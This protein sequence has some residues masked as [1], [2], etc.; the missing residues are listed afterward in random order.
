AE[1]I[2]GGYTAA[3]AER[4]RRTKSALRTQS[5]ARREVRRL[6]AERTMRAGDAARADRRNSKRAISSR[7]HDAKARIDAARVSG[8][9]GAA[10]RR[11]DQLAGRLRQARDR[12]DALGMTK[13]RSTRVI[14]PGRKGRRSTVLA[15]SATTLPIGGDTF[16]VVP[17]LRVHPGERVAVSGPN[18]AG[19][20]TLIRH[21][22]AT[23]SIPRD[24]M[25][26]VPQEVPPADAIA[27]L[28]RLADLPPADL[29]RALTIVA[30]LGSDP[31]ALL[32]SDSPSPGEMRKLMLGLGTLAPPEVIVMDEPTNHLDLPSVEAL[33]VTLR[34]CPA[35]LVLVSHDERFLRS[36]ACT[37]LWS[38]EAGAVRPTT[39][40]PVDAGAD[41]R[42]P[43]S[44]P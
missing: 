42:R 11:F 32:E 26:H 21:L 3:A 29:G 6:E 14:M 13:T 30:S 43:D 24:V 35:A 10:G 44:C 8:R 19:K 4:E 40:A 22:V 20:S 9:D 37:T 18:G 31:A 16:L 33:E 39:L 25:L 1:A 15:C 41:V 34:D 36:A 12:A 38:V 28:E 5:E 7:D 2:P 27:I 23:A 17:A